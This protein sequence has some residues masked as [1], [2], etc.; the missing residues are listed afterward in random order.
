[1]A[2]VT[3]RLKDGTI[4]EPRVGVGGAEPRPRR[5]TDAET[6][7]AGRPAGPEAFHAAAAAAATATDP[8]EDVNTSADYR[9]DLV[10]TLTRRA[11][12]RAAATELGNG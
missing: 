3:Y 4:V 12:E 10:R 9:R 6:A 2:L 7:L 8:L 1:M 11:L 5:I